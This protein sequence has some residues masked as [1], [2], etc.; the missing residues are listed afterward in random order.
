MKFSLL[1]VLALVLFAAQASALYCY[2]CNWEQSNWRCL[3]AEKC[4]DEDQYCVTNV[5]SVGI[6]QHLNGTMETPKSFQRPWANYF[7]NLPR[8]LKWLRNPKEAIPEDS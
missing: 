5:A 4:S 2:T 6:G 8:I 1:A 3:K 7:V